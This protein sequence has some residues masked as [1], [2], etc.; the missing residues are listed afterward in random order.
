[1]YLLSSLTKACKLV[2]DRVRTR[3]PIHISLLK[4]ILDGVKELYWDNGQNYLHCLYQALFCSGYFGLLRSGE[5]TSGPHP[6]LAIDV[7]VGQNKKKILF[8]LRTSKTHGLDSK[9]QF[10]KIT[11]DKS[12]KNLSEQQRENQRTF[13][14]FIIIRNYVNI[15]PVC[16][17]I[18]EPFFVFQ[19][20]NPVRPYHL[21][22]VLRTVL[23]AKGFDADYYCVTGLRS[24]HASDLRKNGIKISTIQKLGRW[25]SNAVYS[26]L[27]M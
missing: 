27:R 20:N 6:V 18:N 21:R 7:H 1:M 9:P 3:L 17:S 11:G 4:I 19:D 14:P 15:R 13:C 25:S 16:L 24:G 5:L 26:Y 2:N 23:I 10:V 8:I 22:N 12:K